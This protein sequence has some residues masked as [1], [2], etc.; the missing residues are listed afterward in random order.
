MHQFI[1]VSVEAEIPQQ[2]RN[3]D[4]YRS[5]K[6]DV[7]FCAFLKAFQSD[8]YPT[9]PPFDNSSLSNFSYKRQ[10]TNSTQENG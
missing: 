10:L 2:K 4:E 8:N 3:V 1:L 7:D 5:P 9:L 6:T